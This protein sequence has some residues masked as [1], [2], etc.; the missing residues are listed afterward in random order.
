MSPARATALGAALAGTVA[1]GAGC[2]HAP[3]TSC[4]LTVELPTTDDVPSGRGRATRSDG[5]AF[6]VAGTWAPSPSSSITL[7]VLSMVIQ[8][9]ETGL[10]VDD[11]IA[12][13]AFPICVPQ[14]ERSER[15][16]QANLVQGGFVTD[17]QHDGGVAILGREGNDLVGR[18]AFTLANRDGD[19]ITFSDGTFRIPQR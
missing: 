18:F 15:S 9:D 12:E 10:P 4:G 8:F 11:L 19:T 13:G 14:G 16:G 17:A 5:E 2:P 6:D 7:G 1:L 3:E